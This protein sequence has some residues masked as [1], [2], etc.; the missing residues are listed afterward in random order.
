MSKLTI[1]ERMKDASEEEQE[2]DLA[3][4]KSK[5]G[6][7]GETKVQREERLRQMMDVDGQ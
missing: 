6:E 2:E 3:L 1:I 5:G 4:P 7:A